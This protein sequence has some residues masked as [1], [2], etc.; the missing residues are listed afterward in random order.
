[1]TDRLLL[2]RALA[3][4]VA[5]SGGAPDSGVC[6]P[7]VERLCSAAA[8][9]LGASGAALTCAPA[10]AARYT[11]CAT[12]DVAARLAELEELVGDGPASRAAR[13]GRS[14]GTVLGPGAPGRPAELPPDVPEVPP[15]FAVL[16]GGVV[17]PGAAVS[18]RSWPVRV[19]GRPVA[20]LT[21]HGP[22]RCAT[23]EALADGQ[24]LADALGPALVGPAVAARSARA[25]R[26]RAVGMLVAQTGLAPDD[27]VALLRARAWSEDVPVADLE[28]AVLARRATFADGGAAGPL[29]A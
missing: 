1:V 9:L 12:D 5:R 25:R 28:D 26:H 17:D 8:A 6:P 29:T 7:A 19:D 14:V 23:T 4:A 27:A 11:A 20:A 21:V 2:L 10:G 22:A 16:A 18:V 15:V 24:V 3:E 13:H